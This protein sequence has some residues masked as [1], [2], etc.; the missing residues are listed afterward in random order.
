MET[1]EVFSLDDL[2]IPP[3]L[4]VYGLVFLFQWQRTPDTR[5][6]AD[7]ASLPDLFFAH[8]TVTNACAT[9][10]L[11]S[12][13]LNSLPP[14]Q[15]GPTLTPFREFALLLPPDLRGDAIGESAELR[16]A[17]N[18]FEPPD[19]LGLEAKR[20][21]SSEGKAFHYVAYVPVAGRVYELDGL[22]QGPI[23][24]GPADP[25]APTPAP[26]TTP[27]AASDDG[28]DAA[29]AAVAVGSE[30]PPRGWEAP[31]AR[32][33]QDRIALFPQ[34]S[35]LEFSLM[36]VQQSRS[37]ALEQ[38]AATAREIGD[39]EGVAEAEEGIKEEKVRWRE[40][41]ATNARRAHN[42]L[43]FV[44]EL[45]R[46]LERDGKL[47]ALIEAAKPASKKREEKESMKLL[48]GNMGNDEMQQLLALMYWKE[49]A[50]RK[51]KN[52]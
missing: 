36:R 30:A 50:A 13:L 22:K 1:A 28:A 35:S 19:T 15:R 2:L 3:P 43:P 12:V 14:S 26:A 47:D 10:A 6:I 40:I 42:Y 18:S 20:P 44:I 52:K 31:A 16:A 24:V 48:M 51:N 5:P 9:Q 25:S 33:I 27:A 23:D 49:E 7:P 8:Q 37:A 41:E 45:L 17:H 32:A 11:L 39:D 29:P 34:Q 46:A 21:R 4:P 38:A